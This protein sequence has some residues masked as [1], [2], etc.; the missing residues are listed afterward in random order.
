L[1]NVIKVV[2][3]YKP[4]NF[5]LLM[6]EK[7]LKIKA[8]LLIHNENFSHEEILINPQKFPKIKIGDILEIK[9]INKELQ[10]ENEDKKKKLFIIINNIEPIKGVTEV[11]IIK[12]IADNFKL[13]VN[14]E[15]SIQQY[16]RSEIELSHIEVIIKD[17]YITRGLLWS[18]IK[19]QSETT[20]YKNKKY[21]FEGLNGQ[22][23]K[24]LRNEEEVMSGL[25]TEDTKVTFR[26]RST[27]I[28]WLIQVSKEMFE[29]S[30]N[31]ELYYEKVLNFSKEIFTKW[32][33]YFVN[34]SLFIIFFSRLFFF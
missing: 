30:Q 20:A 19:K 23:N 25:I 12:E 11:S 26:T 15:I 29:Y 7:N 21:Q 18:F 5:N 32:K 6:N 9:N 1:T 27:K 16:E 33:E 2:E 28:Y 34:H 3:K 24:L 13:D 31:G 17:D 4:T 14:K 10:E 22:L 8:T